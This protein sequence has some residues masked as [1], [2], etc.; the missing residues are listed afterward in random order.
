MRVLRVLAGMVLLTVAVP[1]LLAGAFSWYAMQHRDES[2]RFQARLEP[3]A[4]PG[5]AVVVPDVDAVLQRD[6]PFT[7]AG[8]TSVRLTATAGTQPLFVGLASPGDVAALLRD[9]PFTRL[10]GFSLRRG[11]LGTRVAA[12]DGSAVPVSKPADQPM[13]LAS[14]VG[15]LSFEPSDWRGKPVTLVV[16]T[17]DA[18][19]AESVA[20]TAAVHFGWLDSTTWGLLIL[21]PVVLLL[22]FVVLAWPAR[23]VVYVMAAPRATA[24]VITWMDVATVELP[25]LTAPAAQDPGKIRDNAQILAQDPRNNPDPAG[26]PDPAGREGRRGWER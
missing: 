8:R 5:Y 13:W 7:R 21:G 22:G 15:G 1:A 4:H 25:V 19:K 14:G 11:P 16:M 17:R 18:Q 9:A 12:V 10:D 3:V 6:A 24:P 20:L 26:S 2:G 23:Q